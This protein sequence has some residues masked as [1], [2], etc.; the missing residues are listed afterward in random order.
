M[1]EQYLQ[2]GASLAFVTKDNMPA[3][4][5]AKV[6]MPLVVPSECAF[7]LLKD[8]NQDISTYLWLEDTER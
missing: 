8:Q 6:F 5:K 7:A 1:T 3:A 4:L 2:S